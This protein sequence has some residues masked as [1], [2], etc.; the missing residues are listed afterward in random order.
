VTNPFTSIFGFVLFMVGISCSDGGSGQ[1][2]EKKSIPKPG[3]VHEKIVCA[4]RPGRS[5]ALYLPEPAPPQTSEA[6]PPGSAQRGQDQP[7]PPPHQRSRNSGNQLYPVLIVF[8]PHGDGMFPLKLYQNLAEKYGFIMLGSNDSKN[9]LPA[10]EVNSIADALIHEARTVYPVD[11]NRIYLLGFSGGARVAAMAALYQVQVKGII[12][13]GAG[14]GNTEQPIKYK[15][16]Y[17]G[18]A[19]TADFNMHEMLQLDD[20]LTRAGFRHF[21]TTFPGIH[22]WPPV[23]VMEDGFIWITLNAM[24]DGMVKKDDSFI[25]GV[26]TWFEKR[27]ETLVKN[28]ELIGAANICREAVSFLEGLK[29]VDYFNGELTRLEKQPAYLAQLALRES[30][31]KSE[32]EEKQELMQALQAKDLAWWTKRI[33]NFKSRVS[34]NELINSKI[35]PEDTLKNRRLLSFL[36]LYCYMNANAALARQDENAAIK[37]IAIYELVDPVNPE[38]NYMRAVLLA[39]RSD[40]EAA[41]TQLSMSVSKGF[42]D[43]ARLNAQPEFRQL[44]SSTSWDDLMKSIK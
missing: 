34:K 28:N 32:E 30:V 25:S 18:I 42:T 16:D 12:G 31:M 20:A 13:C 21:I 35:N 27:F 24:K 17:F 3:V 37:I 44:N 38:P 9:G 33:S 40:N 10:E 29:P 41:L 19:G 8:D 39:R 5:Y 15:F 4:E 6:S 23:A 26:N 2:H 1:G 43:K 22:A 14:F 11:T 36:S 7:S